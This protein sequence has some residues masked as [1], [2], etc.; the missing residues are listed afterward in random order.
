VVRTSGFHPGNRGSIPLGATKVAFC[1][2]F[3]TSHKVD[4]S[5]SNIHNHTKSFFYPP[6]E[7]YTMIV[8]SEPSADSLAEVVRQR[9]RL[10]LGELVRNSPLALI[11]RGK[12][13]VFKVIRHLGL[14]A[15]PT[16]EDIAADHR[17]AM[18]HQL[19]DF[20]VPMGS[21]LNER[22]FLWRFCC[23]STDQSWRA[24]VSIPW[25]WSMVDSPATKQGLEDASR[26]F[27]IYLIDVWHLIAVYFL[28]TGLTLGLLR[29]S[30]EGVERIH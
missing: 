18:L 27:G 1:H 10:Q 13:A 7:G 21:H 4:N 3:D 20:V 22:H 25:L 17:P 23:L 14:P 15:D 8:W 6:K 9:E 12:T 5:Y 16:V 2:F 24:K 26:C 11:V 30:R 19:L 28:Q 29:W